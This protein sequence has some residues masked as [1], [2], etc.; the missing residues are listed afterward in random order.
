MTDTSPQSTAHEYWE[1]FYRDRESPWGRVRRPNEPLVREVSELPPG[2]ALD[3]GCSEGTDAI[4]LADRGWRVT[5]VDVS[6]T[7]L[8]RAAA[9]AA[10]AGVAE[11]I[12]WQ[13]HDLSQSFP[14]GHFD[15]V[16]AQFLHSPVELEGERT[17]ILRRAAEAVAP[18]GVL[19]IVG[20]AG[21][22]SWQHTPHFDY[23]FP[24]TAEVLDSLDLAPGRWRVERD[25][26]FTRELTD[27]D[28][29][30]GTREDNVLRLRHTA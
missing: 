3:L 15:L 23:H 22:P 29:L 12:D 13:R 8:R 5:A 14:A 24:T 4:W 11:W 6:A 17:A 1:E 21:W 18:G 20:H 19:L 10:H 7:A 9:N 26:L 16:S 2:T 28:G 27:P 25:E 30:P